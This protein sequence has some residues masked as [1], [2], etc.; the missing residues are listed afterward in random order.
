[1]CVCHEHSSRKSK[2]TLKVVTDS[3]ALGGSACTNAR[4][5][6]TLNHLSIPCVTS[7]YISRNFAGSRRQKGTRFLTDISS[8]RPSQ[9]TAHPSGTYRTPCT[10][11][12][13]SPLLCS[14][15]STTEGRRSR[16]YRLQYVSSQFPL[17]NVTRLY[18][19]T[20]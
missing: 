16:V 13:V 6:M 2:R 19:V 1:M 14:F 3:S 12:H 20:L 18:A 15:F 17:I 4:I 7:S 8:N 9:A 10:D 5:S 11:N